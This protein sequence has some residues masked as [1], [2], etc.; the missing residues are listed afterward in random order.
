V[1]S[2]KTVSVD[3][4]ETGSFPFHDR[5][6]ILSLADLYWTWINARDAAEERAFEHALDAARAAGFVSKSLFIR[7]ARWKSVRNTPRYQSNSEADVRAATSA[8]FAETDDA[9]ALRALM[10][11]RGVGLRTASAILHWMR[12]DRFPILDFRML[13]ALGIPEPR[14]YDDVEFYGKIAERVRALAA[15]HALDLRTI[16][17]ALWTW[18][19]GRSPS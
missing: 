1:I 11:L 5:R 16:D 3:G 14:S 13:A 9:T 12:P 10:R 19:K 15:S 6:A 4:S 8:A 7:L 17:R 18:D 2:L